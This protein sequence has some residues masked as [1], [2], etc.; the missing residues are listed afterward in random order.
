MSN[1][2]FLPV[3]LTDAQLELMQ[4]M[5]GGMSEEAMKDLKKKLLEFI[6]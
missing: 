2:A 4:R 5:A 3:P 6:F 1:S